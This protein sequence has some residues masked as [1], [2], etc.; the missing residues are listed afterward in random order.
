MMVMVWTKDVNEMLLRYGK[1]IKE[2]KNN[3]SN[4]CRLTAR[5]LFERREMGIQ[6]YLETDLVHLLK[7]FTETIS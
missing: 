7:D 5:Y 6:P 4:A 1:K 3:E 2:G